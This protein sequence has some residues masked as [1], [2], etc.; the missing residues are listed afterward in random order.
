M[1]IAAVSSA[2]RQL[3]STPV[4]AYRFV[5]MLSERLGPQIANLP[6]L[7]SGSPIV[8]AVLEAWGM[9]TIALEDGSESSTERVSGESKELTRLATSELSARFQNLVESILGVITEIKPLALFLDDLHEA[10]NAYVIGMCG[11]FIAERC[12]SSLNIVEALINSRSRLVRVLL[13]GQH[14]TNQDTYRSFSPRFGLPTGKRLNSLASYLSSHHVP[15]RQVTDRLRSI[16]SY[17]AR[18]TWIT[19]EQLPFSAISLLVAK[20]LHRPREECS[21]LARVVYTT[22]G[23]NAFL[24]R[25]ILSGMRRYHHV[26]VGV[27][28]DDHIAHHKA[29]HL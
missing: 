26:R 29:D 13:R 21:R 2:L 20:A 10:D 12:R 27:Y 19:L 22:S 24:A 7:Y 1:Q 11:E 18:A 8:K 28:N 23:G 25:N 9:N 15:Y 14:W 4:D 6:L 17:R 5:R 16:C 3:A